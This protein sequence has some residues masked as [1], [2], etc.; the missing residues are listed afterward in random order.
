MGLGPFGGS[1]L[2]SSIKYDFKCQASRDPLWYLLC[3]I[4]LSQL[5]RYCLNI[6]S[7]C[8]FFCLSHLL[9]DICFWFFTLDC[10]G[11]QQL[12]FIPL[13]LWLLFFLLFVCFVFSLWLNTVS[14]D[15][16]K[17]NKSVGKHDTY[18]RP[19][20]SIT[21]LIYVWHFLF[22]WQVLSVITVVS[23]AYYF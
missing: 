22:I 3:Y 18:V 8:I 19:L 9:T 4:S 15:T 14:Q 20:M 1:G 5:C 6:N 17:L 12:A 7:V 2:M 23:L 11:N 13:S 16:Q 10:G 21:A